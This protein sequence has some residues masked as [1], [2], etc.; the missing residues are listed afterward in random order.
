MLHSFNGGKFHSVFYMCFC[1]VFLT[2]HP[3][4]EIVLVKFFGL[5][6]GTHADDTL[7]DRQEVLEKLIESM[8]CVTTA[9]NEIENRM[10]LHANNGLQIQSSFIVE[11]HFDDFNP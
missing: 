6:P 11:Q 10:N 3:F 2:V 9:I 7:R 4:K 1:T 8:V 5:G